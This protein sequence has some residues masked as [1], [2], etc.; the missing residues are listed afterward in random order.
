MFKSN[1]QM[2]SFLSM[3]YPCIPLN[4]WPCW[5]NRLP[6]VHTRMTKMIVD[7]SIR[8]YFWCVC[9]YIYIHRLYTYYIHACFWAEMRTV[10]SNYT[11][12]AGAIGIKA[13]VGMN[14]SYRRTQM[15]TTPSND[16]KCAPKTSIVICCHLL[17]GELQQAESTIA[18]PNR[19]NLESWKMMGNTSS[20]HHPGPGH[21]KMIAQWYLH[22]TPTWQNHNA[23]LGHSLGS[24]KSCVM[25]D[26]FQIFLVF[27]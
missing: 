17:V 23:T 14:H 15:T 21:S 1:L 6:D 3:N 4:I 18:N 27:S 8:S 22:W 7:V 25:L 16:L 13:H 24:K 19:E 5:G 12:T 9:V 11:D 2:Y 20:N 26:G 10:T